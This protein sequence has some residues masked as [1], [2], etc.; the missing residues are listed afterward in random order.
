MVADWQRQARSPEVM[1]TLEALWEK[2]RRG[3][4]R[5]PYCTDDDELFHLE[6]DCG[7]HERVCASD[8]DC[9]WR[10]DEANTAQGDD[11]GPAKDPAQPGDRNP[12]PQAPAGPGVGAQASRG[13]GVAGAQGLRVGKGRGTLPGG[14][15]M[16]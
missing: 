8:D 11:D 5:C 14:R 1:G 15:G 2:W 13:R 7:Y 6:C 10:S 3:E 4:S 9:E 16:A 12:R